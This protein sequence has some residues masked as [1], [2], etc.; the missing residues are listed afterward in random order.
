MTYRFH[1][2]AEREHLAR[3]SYYEGERIALGA[4]YLADFESTIAR[5]CEAPAR[6]KCVRPPDIRRALFRTFPVP[7][8]TGKCAARSS[9][10]RSR[11]IASGRGIGW[12]GCSQAWVIDPA[13]TKESRVRT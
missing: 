7:S 8:F 11:T 12:R 3:V 9:C 10:S 6:L 1:V 13:P 5:I 4:R 2:R